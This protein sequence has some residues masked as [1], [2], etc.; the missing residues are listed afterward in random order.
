MAGAGVISAIGHS[1]PETLES[2]RQERWAL[3]GY[4]CLIRFIKTLPV[5]EVKL[6]NAELAEK[7]HS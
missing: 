4:R 6:T 5:G 1:R 7:V 2:F 3:A